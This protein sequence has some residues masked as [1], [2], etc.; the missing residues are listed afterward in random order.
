MSTMLAVEMQDDVFPA[1]QEEP[2]QMI[3]EMRLFS[4]M[5]WYELGRVSQSKAA[6]IA[7]LSRADFISEMSRYSVSPF[8]ETAA[9]ICRGFED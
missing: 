8:Q 6:E 1:L 9:E 2:E 7:G 3:Q 5:K 4:A